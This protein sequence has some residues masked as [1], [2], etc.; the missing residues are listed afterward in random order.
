MCRLEILLSGGVF[1]I[2]WKNLFNISKAARCVRCARLAREDLPMK[3][4]GALLHQ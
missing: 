4:V 3:E 1:S 2:V